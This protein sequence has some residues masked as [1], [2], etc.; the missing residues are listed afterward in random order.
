MQ[1]HRNPFKTVVLMTWKHFIKWAFLRGVVWP[2]FIWGQKNLH[3]IRKANLL[4]QLVTKRKAEG[5]VARELFGVR[6]I[7]DVFALIYGGVCTI[8]HY[9]LQKEHCST[10][11]EVFYF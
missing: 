9:H 2:V 6:D 1:N 5:T 11:T 10:F 4:F 3:V 7:F 8:P